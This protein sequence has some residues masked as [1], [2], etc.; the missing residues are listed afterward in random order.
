MTWLKRLRPK[1]S[2]PSRGWING[3]IES[4]AAKE[5]VMAAMPG[6]DSLRQEGYL[7]GLNRLQL[8]QLYTI[9]AALNGE[10]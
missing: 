7:A 2:L 4:L 9:L 8:N 5:A 3:R 6:A 1:P 10:V